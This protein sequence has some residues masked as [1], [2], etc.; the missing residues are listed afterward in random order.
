VL[1]VC[2][3]MRFGGYVCGML[4]Q[5]SCCLYGD[6][7]YVLGMVYTVCCARRMFVVLMYVR[8]S[9]LRVFMGACVVVCDAVIYVY[10][11]DVSW[12]CC[13]VCVVLDIC[14]WEMSVVLSYM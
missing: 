4:H 10:V 14:H 12:C 11:R 13:D 6:L 5:F 7:R 3:R 8:M 1:F 9:Y 2:A